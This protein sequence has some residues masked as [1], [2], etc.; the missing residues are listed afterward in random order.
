MYKHPKNNI[1]I[2]EASIDNLANI[3]SIIGAG[4]LSDPLI[5]SLV[6]N[7]ADR[8]KVTGDFF[9]L[10]SNIAIEQGFMDVAYMDNLDMV[11]IAIWIPSN[12]NVDL[13]AN[14]TAK[15]TGSYKSKFQSLSEKLAV[16][17]P[18]VD[19][20]YSLVA[21][22][23]L[24]VAHGLG[25]GGALL[26]HRLNELDKLGVPT[27]LEASTRLAAGGIYQRHG[28]KPVG[29]PINFSK[30]VDAFPMWREAHAPFKPFTGKK[31]RNESIGSIVRFGEYNWIILDIQDNKKLL[32]S[33]NVLKAHA[34]HDKYEN[35]VWRNSTA[36]KYLNEDFYNTFSSQDKSKIIL[37]KIK[38]ENNPWFGSDGG[39]N[40]EEHVFLLSIGEVVKYFGDSNQL[41]DKNQNTKFFIN[42]DFNNLRKALN[43]EDEKSAWWLRTPGSTNK[44]TG[45]VTTDGRINV[46]GDFVNRQNSFNIGI[47]PAIW[48]TD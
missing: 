33:E 16:Y 2:V 39:K 41:I 3:S 20:Y 24:P 9:G 18:P 31:F 46:S 48:I 10:F 32:I 12:A 15:V 14:N 23:I 35:I 30:G 28:Y 34:Y 1:R 45:F 17:Y 42:D 21:I 6:E 43:L 4:F 11:G 13:V 25:I 38:S 44:F 29:E 5:M 37:T 40:T 19:F 36:R 7:H 8:F 22:S 27:Y 26:R 47:R